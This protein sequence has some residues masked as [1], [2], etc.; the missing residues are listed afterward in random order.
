MA[1]V[2]QEADRLR[3]TLRRGG[4]EP[5]VPLIVDVAAAGLPPLR[6]PLPVPPD[7]LVFA[8]NFVAAST[9]S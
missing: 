6:T 8:P 3:L 4:V 2:T 9:R 1:S 7:R 5:D